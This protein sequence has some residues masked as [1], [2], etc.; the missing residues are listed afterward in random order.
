MS[1]ARI[2]R[3]EVPAPAT[4]RPAMIAGS[5]LPIS[6][7]ISWVLRG[8]GLRRRAPTRSRLSQA[9]IADQVTV[10]RVVTCAVVDGK[11][12]AIS[13]RVAAAKSGASSTSWEAM[14]RRNRRPE[15]GADSTVTEA[16]SIEGLLPRSASH[17]PHI[18]TC[19]ST[20]SSSSSR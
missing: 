8:R 2:A 4:F 15:S 20:T 11:V 16:P 17:P 19:W 3:T 12:S 6:V 10:I 5:R 14:L 18:A 1:W 13:A 7:A 9:G